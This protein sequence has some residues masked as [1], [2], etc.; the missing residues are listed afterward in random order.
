MAIQ[1]ARS[2]TGMSQ[3]NGILRFCSGHC[4]GNGNGGIEIWIDLHMPFALNHLHKPRL[5]K[6]SHFQ[7]VHADRSRM[8]LRCDTECWSFWLVALHAPHSGHSLNSRSD[9]WQST[10]ELLAQ[11]HD[12]DPLFILMD[13]SAVPGDADGQVVLRT[14]FTTSVNTKDMRTLLE[15]LQLYLPA[16]SEVHQGEHDTWTNFTGS[17]A[18][19]FDHIAIPQSWSTRCSHSQVIQEF[20]MATT[21][22]DHRAVAI[23]LQW[24]G[25]GPVRDPQS[26]HKRFR[27]DQPFVNGPNFSNYILDCPP[28]LWQ[29]DVATHTARLTTYLHEVLNVGS[30]PV[31]PQP[32]K[33]YISDEIWHM[34]QNK[35]EL[36]KQIKATRQRMT[37]TRLASCFAAWKSGRCSPHHDEER[38]YDV[39]LRCSVLRLSTKLYVVCKQMKKSLVQ[40]KQI[41][42][43]LRLKE[44]TETSAAEVLRSLRQ[45]TGPTNPRKCKRKPL[46]IVKDEEGVICSLPTDALSV[47]IRF[48]QHMEGG[49]R[50][51]MEE[52]RKIWVDELEMFQREEVVCMADNLPTPTDLEVAL[53]RI[54]KGKARGPD[55]IPGE[56]CH[57]ISSICDCEVALPYDDEDDH[58]WTRTFGVQ[59]WAPDGGLQRSRTTGCLYIVPVALSVQSSRESDS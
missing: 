19:C 15:S 49:Q 8:V 39:S 50:M 36:K 20:D 2:E 54:P 1:E 26:S 48:F 16:T 35:I 23:Q 44:V 24:K 12:G 10:H 52:L 4:Q 17:S 6:R 3:N 59:R 57:Y 51:P 31:Q 41:A 40:A 53:R 7:L 42:L 27:G 56:L 33:C 11:H 30:T 25:I 37:F 32:K 45:F 18:H 47:W 9:W 28:Q 13:A 43:E 34:R 58:T 21:H 22:E 14:G 5:F 38:G 55:G 46:P 29:T